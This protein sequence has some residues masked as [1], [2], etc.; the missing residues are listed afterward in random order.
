MSNEGLCDFDT[1][2]LSCKR[3]G[4]KARR[5]PTFRKCRTLVEMAKDIAAERSVK[6]IS[7]PPAR[8]GSGIQAAL[9]SVGITSKRVEAVT[10]RPC[11]CKQR[12]AWLD[13]VG[14]AASKAVG[15]ALNA[16][17]NAV[18]PHPVTTDDVVAVADALARSPGTNAGLKSKYSAR[19]WPA[20]E[21]G[22]SHQPTG[23]R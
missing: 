9:G 21:G 20:T 1:E 8:I 3:C 13:R 22:R 5:L 18:A 10:G 12:A 17:A 16:V 11:G 6:R 2:T 15:R 23:V 7:L 19:G 4:F 14:E